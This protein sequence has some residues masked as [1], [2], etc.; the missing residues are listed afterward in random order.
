[1]SSKKR[2]LADE[3]H[4]ARRKKLILEFD[5]ICNAHGVR[6]K[7]VPDCIFVGLINK[8]Y[9]S[10]VKPTE[11]NEALR[12][13]R[14]TQLEDKYNTN[15]L[16]RESLYTIA[17]SRPEKLRREMKFYYCCNPGEL[18]EIDFGQW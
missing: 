3:A 2:K 10:N 14:K 4:L 13:T 9:Q 5:N 7:W 17:R 11:L 12:L 18:P 8:L 16:F 1:M 15:G 6:R